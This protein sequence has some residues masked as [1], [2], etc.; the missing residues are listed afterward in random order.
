M[1]WFNGSIA[2]KS[3]EFILIHEVLLCRIFHV[4]NHTSSPIIWKLCKS[5]KHYVNK[6]RWEILQKHW[7]ILIETKSFRKLEIYFL[8]EFYQIYW[9]HLRREIFLSRPDF[10]IT[11]EVDY[12]LRHS[13]EGMWGNF[14]GKIWIFRQI[15]AS[16]FRSLSLRIK[17]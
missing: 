3:A 15:S 9:M 1:L 17:A 8:V 12:N 5:Q 10:V 11:G 2:L 13:V 16:M 6:L 4:Y 7:E 14:D